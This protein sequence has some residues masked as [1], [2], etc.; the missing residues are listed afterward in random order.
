MAR[1][2]ARERRREPACVPGREAGAAGRG[3][4]GVGT[5][6]LRENGAKVEAI[7]ASLA[8][9][10]AR[11]GPL[12]GAG[13]AAGVVGVGLMA[14][15]A[16]QTGKEYAVLGAK[17][18]AAGADALLRQYEGR[19]AGG[20]LGGIGAGAAYGAL[21]G[22]ETGPGAI[23]TGIVGGVV[24]AFAGEKLANKIT[25]YKVDHQ[26]GS[27]GRTYSYDDGQWTGTERHID[28]KGS[29]LP[30]L[31]SNTAAA[32]DGQRPVLD[33]KRTAAVTELALAHPRQQD[34]RNITLDGTEWHASHG[35]WT[36]QVYDDSVSIDTLGAFPVSQRQPADA[37]TATTLD[38][39][40]ANRQ[41]NN[42]HYGED[43]AKAYV[44]DHYGR[45]WN[46]VGPLPDAVAS[47]LHRP[48]ETN[49]KDP[50]TGQSWTVDGHGGFSRNTYVPTM[51]GV[52]IAAPVPADP[53]E[54]ARLDK[55]R[56]DAVRSNAAYGAQVIHEAYKETQNQGRAEAQDQHA[57]AANLWTSVS[58]RHLAA[59]EQ[60]RR[61]SMPDQQ[62]G[63]AP[64]AQMPTVQVQGLRRG[65]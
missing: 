40:T 44:M 38:R 29:W 2:P 23:A 46:R 16:Y 8:R 65:L 9:G 43:V 31:A 49:V 51:G 55:V 42:D 47:E 60:Q 28:W 26:T 56:N 1:E 61:T 10:A 30:R 12:E 57:A 4:E 14:V 41:Y 53:A 37:R 54:T 21:A 34:T 35:T 19:T 52:L 22:S 7:Q 45:G 6:G 20:I 58:Q 11:A 3:R 50:A 62:A 63:Q 25:E 24:G 48:S 27:D 64:A 13:R 36:K 5:E 59:Q 33:Y 18:N 15:D 39:L 17:G 32:A